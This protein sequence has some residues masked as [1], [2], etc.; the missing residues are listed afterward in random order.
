[1]ADITITTETIA[2]FFSLGGGLVAAVVALFWLVVSGYR[3]GVVENRHDLEYCQQLLREKKH[4]PEISNSEIKR[5][6][7]PAS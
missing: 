3:E 7:D 4:G 2:F 6:D 1:M 5:D